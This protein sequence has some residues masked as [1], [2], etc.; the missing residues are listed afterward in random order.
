LPTLR[1]RFDPDIGVP[2]LAPEKAWHG[3]LRAIEQITDR[4]RVEV[5]PFIRRTTGTIRSI[6]DPDRPG[7]M[8]S[9][10]LGRLDILGLDTSARG[11]PHPMVE[12]GASY[13]FIRA[14]SDSDDPALEMDPLDRLPSHR[15]DGWVQVTP[16]R[17]LSLRGRVSYFGQNIDRG[18]SL[19]GY[20][21]IE[22]TVT[23]PITKEYLAVLR[24]DDLTNVAPET[25]FNFHGPGRVISLIVQGTWE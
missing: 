7:E 9:T 19:P 5:A 13:S 11:K 6:P 23:A 16:D 20:S 24:V 15:A 14:R 12:V 21:L 25:R 17:R 1:E 3:E 22:A 18:E 8:T 2:G 4:I 10:N